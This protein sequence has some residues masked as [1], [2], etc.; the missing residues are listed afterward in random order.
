MSTTTPAEIPTTGTWKIDTVHSSVSFA[1][2][3]NVVGTFRGHIH[4]VTG[5]LV[6]GVLSG[7]V[8]VENLDPG[9]PM[10]K[11]HLLGGD[12]WFDAANYPTLS[13]TSTDLHAHGDQLH[14]AGELTLRGVTKP[15][16]ISGSVRG[17]LEV[18]IAD[19][20][21]S[22]RLGLELSTTINRKEFGMTGDGKVKDDVTIIVDLELALQA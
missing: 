5:A 15:V 19:G 11:D 18:T 21:Q 6:D 13:F 7:E 9:L 16:A 14:A 8:Q 1:V 3:H 4:D 10:L 22:T 17:P 12:V 2:G 20:S